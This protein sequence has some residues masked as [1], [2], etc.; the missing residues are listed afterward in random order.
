MLKV[1]IFDF[2]Y[3]L[4]DSTNGIVLSANDALEQ[5]GE[6][7]RSYEE[8]KKTIGLSL[9]ETYKAL[10]GNVDDALAE[11]FSALFKKKADEVMVPNTELYEGVKEML[12][13]LREKGYRTGIVTTKFQYRIQN[14]LKK[15]DACELIDVIVG[16]ENV[17]AVKPDPEGLLL[18][19]EQLGVAKDEVLYVGDSYVDAQTAESAGVK[20]AGVLTG[21]TTREDFMKY[22]HMTIGRHV[23][24]IYEFVENTG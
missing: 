12:W 6:C 17:K 10:T 18:A 5:M 21:T 22:S 24:E 19:I 1:I 4:G 2:D 11:Q 16:A 20:F 15:F 14:I 7:T 9:K 13:K 8:I 3:T 23:R